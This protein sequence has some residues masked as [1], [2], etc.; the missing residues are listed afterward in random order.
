[1]TLVWTVKD[2]SPEDR[3]RLRG[4]ANGFLPKG[5]AGDRSLLTELEARL[6]ASSRKGE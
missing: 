2:L 6:G 3:S 1:L 5:E 4:A